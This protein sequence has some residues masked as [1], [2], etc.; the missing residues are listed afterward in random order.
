MT[1][2]FARLAGIPF[3]TFVVVAGAAASDISGKW[4]VDV[5][6]DSS[7]ISG[8]ARSTPAFLRRTPGV[9]YPP[10]SVDVRASCGLSFWERE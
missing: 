10:A 4:T 9:A 6:Y 3:I 2:S 5:R 8:G 7:G 1:L